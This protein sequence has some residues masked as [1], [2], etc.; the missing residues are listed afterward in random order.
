MAEDYIKRHLKGKRRARRDEQEIG[1]TCSLLGATVSSRPSP[2]ATLLSLSNPLPTGPRCTR[3]TSASA[4]PGRCSIGQS[5][6]EFMLWRRVLLDRLHPGQLLGPKKH[7]ERVLEDSELGALWRA[8][9]KIGYPHGPLNQLIALTGARRGEAAEAKW[10]EFDLDGGVWAVPAERFKSDTI[11]KVPLS[12]EAVTLL[13]SL[14]RF[15]GGPFVFTT[16]FGRR[17]VGDFSRPK[18]RLEFTDD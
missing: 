3:R 1:T 5:I 11:H 12:P 16:L 2:G 14:P 17:P 7:R 15:N 13:Q 4:T 6:A 18:E 10:E 8:C 9:E